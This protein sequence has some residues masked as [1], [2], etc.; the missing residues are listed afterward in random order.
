MHLTLYEDEGESLQVPASKSPAIM[1][2]CARARPPR[3]MEEENGYICRSCGDCWDPAIVLPRRNCISPF[4]FLLKIAQRSVG[5]QRQVTS[6]DGLAVLSAKLFA[7]LFH[8][9]SSARLW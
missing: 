6:I 3:I 1:E 8:V 7:M 5:F 2:I 9:D 4:H